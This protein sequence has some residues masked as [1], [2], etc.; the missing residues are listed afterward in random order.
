MLR[1]RP[2]SRPDF[3]PPFCEPHR[4][5]RFPGLRGLSAVLAERCPVRG[6]RP[7]RLSGSGRVGFLVRSVPRAASRPSRLERMPHGAVGSWPKVSGERQD[8]YRDWKSRFPASRTTLFVHDPDPSVLESA[9]GAGAIR[10]ADLPQLAEWYQC[11]PVSDSA[12]PPQAV[13]FAASW[14]ELHAPEARL[15]DNRHAPTRSRSRPSARGRVRPGSRPR[16]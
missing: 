13:A 12:F 14:G 1:R 6:E 16:P 5:P 7:P 9:P 11:E 2:L 10:I 3:L 8:H 15:A 4:I